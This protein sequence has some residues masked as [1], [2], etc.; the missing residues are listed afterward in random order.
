MEDKGNMHA[1]CNES[2]ILKVARKFGLREEILKTFKSASKCFRVH[3]SQLFFRITFH[4]MILK[5]LLKL[6]TFND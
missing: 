5:G 3:I 6:S 2:S 4:I 1:K